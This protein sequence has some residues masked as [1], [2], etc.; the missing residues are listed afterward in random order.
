[1]H[2]LDPKDR[3]STDANSPK[4][5]WGLTSEDYDRW[6]P[7]Y[8]PSSTSDSNNGKSDSPVNASLIWVQAWG[9]SLG[10]LLSRAPTVSLLTSAFNKPNKEPTRP[11]KKQWR[12]R[13]PA[14]RIGLYA[15]S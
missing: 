10:H 7:N 8:P 12:K 13:L 15:P 5:D 14:R 6:R 1:M 4:V 11:R 3:P 9:S 2:G